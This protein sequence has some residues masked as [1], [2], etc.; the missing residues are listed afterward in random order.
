MAS[1]KH[2]FKVYVRWKPLNTTESESSLPEIERRIGQEE[3][4][5]NYRQSNSCQTISISLSSSSSAS[6]NRARSRTWKSA[7]SFTKVFPTSTINREVYADVVAPTFPHVIEGGGACNFF[8]YGHSGSGKTHTIM[9]Y[10]YEDDRHLGLCLLT[11]R[12]LFRAI[13]ELIDTEE[14]TPAQCGGKEKA[15]LGVAVRLYEVRGKCAYDLLNHG[16]ECHVR[17]GPDGQTHIRGQTEILEDGKV[18]VRPIVARPCW[19]FDEL[20]KVVLDGLQERKIG[21]SS[22]HDRSSRT[23][24]ILELEVVNKLLLE[25]RNVVIERE[26]ELVP[27]GKKATDVYLEE[28]KKAFIQTPEGRWVPNPGYSVDQQRIDAAEAEKAEYEARLRKAE[29]A[30][31][32]CLRRRQHPCLGGKFVFVDLAG[33]EF[34]DRADDV[35]RGGPKQ[36]PQER[37]QGRQINSDLFALK[38]V[39]RA[40]AL[41]QARIPFRSS[42]L[43]MI[44][45]SHFVATAT[46]KGQ[47]AMILTVSPAEQQF[48]ATMNTLKYGNLV[49]VAGGTKKN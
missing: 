45:R 43:T 48:I 6:S 33:S 20:R 15:K 41:G 47:S 34:F 39:I 18:R 17:E 11:A 9:G 1:Q 30:V 12:E 13:D 21:S 8:A 27:V 37:Q 42:S 40:R 44:L 25:A 35:V 2:P 7:A 22:M 36:T 16:T 23:H 26:S 14:M 4:K 24:A 31:A 28:N 29:D 10:D 38:E 3:E 32:E 49:G 46:G 19:S 5:A